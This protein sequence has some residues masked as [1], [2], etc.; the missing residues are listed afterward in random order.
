MGIKRDARRREQ[1][2]RVDDALV[3]GKISRARE[4]IFEH[5]APILGVNVE[6]M[7]K[8]TSLQPTRVSIAILHQPRHVLSDNRAECFLYATVPLRLQL[9]LT[10]RRRFYA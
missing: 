4:L 8:P 10:V 1:G 2:Q 7:L 9:L 6:A 5:G 3:Q